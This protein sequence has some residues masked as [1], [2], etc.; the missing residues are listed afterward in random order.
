MHKDGD[1]EGKERH[2]I[3]GI[4]ATMLARVKLRILASPCATWQKFSRQIVGC[5]FM[6]SRCNKNKKGKVALHEHPTINKSEHK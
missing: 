1:E 6:L 3:F 5:F 4:I 2:K